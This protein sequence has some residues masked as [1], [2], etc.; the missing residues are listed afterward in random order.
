MLSYEEQAA[1]LDSIE[2]VRQS[3]A[4]Q[5]GPNPGIAIEFVANLHRAVDHVMQAINDADQQMECSQ[6]CACCCSIRVEATEPEI[7]RI[8]RAIR[9]LPAERIAAI[10]ERLHNFAAASDGACRTDCAFL[11]NRHCSI[12]EIRPAV[13]RRAHSLSAESCQ[14][15]S[16]EIPQSLDKLLR[17]DALI[18]GTSEAYREFG[19]HASGHE[20]CNAVLLALTDETIEAKWH[21]GEPVFP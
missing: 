19:L 15:F 13:C 4:R 9:L 11:E 5:L 3:A 17:A 12:Y 16:S 20:L 7:F 21:N 2:R 1:Y 10:V 8:A 14:R 18:K 6:G